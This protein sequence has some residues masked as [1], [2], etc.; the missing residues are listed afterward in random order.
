ME[1]AYA[2]VAAVHRALNEGELSAVELVEHCLSRIAEDDPRVG[3]V[4]AL[5]PGALDRAREIDAQRA[6]PGTARRPLEGIPVL[7]K[8]NVAVTGQPTTAG[9]R[10][11]AESCP[12]DAVLVT[13]LRAAGAVILGKANLSEWANFRS[14]H[15]TSGWSAV[16]GQTHNPHV[17]DRNPSGSSSGSAAAVAAGFAPLAI[18]TETDGSIVSPAGICG[19]VGFKPT[20]GAVPGAGIVPISSAQ[21]V[22]GPLARSVADAALAYAA[23]AGVAV[24]GLPADALRGARVG[25]WTPPAA[26][27]PTRAVLDTAVAAL[28]QAG[29]QAVTV[30]LDPKPVADVEFPALL[31]EFNAELSAYL[32]AAPDARVR[33]LAELIDFNAADDLELVHF[34]QDNLEAAL[35]APGLDEVAY[36]SRRRS[37]TALA[38]AMIDD[39][40]TTHRL[41]AIVTLTN[42]AAWRTDYTVDDDFDVLT[43]TPAAV[44]GYPTISVPAGFTGP[45]PIGVS[46]LG[47]GGSDAR[48]L[49]YAHAFEQVSR[50]WRAP[51]YL[52][53]LD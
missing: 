2:T 40:L 50:A 13:R 24:P 12:P 48:V 42:G 19:V 35:A 52:S 25:V 27:A 29:A 1:L 49:A 4:I 33:S 26:D 32:A 23:L 47:T 20:V 34:G 17:L 14:Q 37:A 31:A 21:D 39:T 3:A 28:A 9:S 16:G 45:L 53:S 8:D 18:G 41:D 44:A 15:S 22:A 51:G 43:S 36:R 11:L 10:A 38:R 6:E 30:E 46:F 7:I 5:D